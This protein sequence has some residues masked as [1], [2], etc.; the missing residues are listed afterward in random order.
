MLRK[1]GPT[2]HDRLAS[3]HNMG[4]WAEALT[5]HQQL[6][7]QAAADLYPTEPP[8]SSG[9][10]P[11]DAQPSD[12]R[13]CQENDDS[14]APSGRLDAAQH[15]ALTCMLHMGHWEAVCSM[16]DGACVRDAL[17]D[18][19]ATAWSWAPY[20]A[21]ACWRL[22]E[23]G[24]L[25][26][27]VN[28]AQPAERGADR[29]PQALLGFDAAW[30]VDLGR[31]LLAVARSDHAG[32]SRLLARARDETM[33]ALMASSMES[34]SRAYPQLAKLHML[35]EVADAA[36]ILRAGGG[37]QQL[38]G[39]QWAERLKSTQPS[40][41]VQVLEFMVGVDLGVGVVCTVRVVMC[42]C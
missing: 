12:G 20:G 13:F 33:R 27:Y 28:T 8:R 35:Q 25:E 2:V 26:E 22:G 6:Q 19:P 32:L 1:G 21:A 30:E 15:G 34:Y 29:A 7:R 11:R 3:A 41:V 14:G 42:L 4:R 16:V 38:R 31:L 5:T 37:R 36:A 9:K 23:W 18:P 39:L 40:L 24:R 17:A 10:R